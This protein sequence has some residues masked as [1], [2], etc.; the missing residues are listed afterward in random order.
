ML[1]EPYNAEIKKKR[2]KWIGT[3][4]TFN[5]LVST[6][7]SGKIEVTRLETLCFD[8][9]ALLNESDAWQFLSFVR[10]HPGIKNIVVCGNNTGP[11]NKLTFTRMPC[12]LVCRLAYLKCAVIYGPVLP[13]LLG[14]SFSSDKTSSCEFS[15]LARDSWAHDTIPL[16]KV[17]FWWPQRVVRI[18]QSDDKGDVDLDLLDVVKA[19]S[20]VCKS[21]LE[22]LSIAVDDDED[23]LDRELVEVISTSFPNLRELELGPARAG[24]MS[25]SPD[26]VSSLFV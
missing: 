6:L 26:H 19:L 23:H 12:D 16:N 24:A 8:A 13:L 22:L 17:H 11:F 18:V 5:S 2:T 10:C 15:G 1:P 9:N 14:F 4:P 20:S 25:R 3:Q 21:T 7:L